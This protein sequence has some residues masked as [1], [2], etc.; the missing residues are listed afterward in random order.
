MMAD[1][2]KKK[3][4]KKKVVKKRT[5]IALCRSH[6]IAPKRRDMNNQEWQDSMYRSHYIASTCPICQHHLFNRELF[7]QNPEVWKKVLTSKELSN[8]ML[9]KV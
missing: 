4:A 9:R 2:T 3:R 5:G 6:K 8:L 1:K 7:P